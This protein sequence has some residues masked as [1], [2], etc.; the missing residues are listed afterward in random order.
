M[1]LG[2]NGGFVMIFK[3]CSIVP[4]KAVSMLTS[5]PILKKY[6]GCTIKIRKIIKKKP[7]DMLDEIDI[8]NA[9]WKCC[10]VISMWSK[11]PVHTNLSY[12]R[13]WH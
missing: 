13:V 7:L 4:M 10:D 1:C 6:D 8:W 3:I 2:D 12:K 9:I 5:W 11:Y